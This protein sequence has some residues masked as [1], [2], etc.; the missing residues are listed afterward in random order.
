GQFGLPRITPRVL[1]DDRLVGLDDAGEVRVRG[2]GLRR[3]QVVEAQ[4]QRAARRHRYAVWPHGFAVGEVERDLDLRVAVAG[5]EHAGRLVAG[6]LPRAARAGGR[7][8]AFR[9]DPQALSDVFHDGSSLRS[10]AVALPPPQP[11][12][13]VAVQGQAM[14]ARVLALVPAVAQDVDHAF[15]RHVRQGNVDRLG[16][17]VGQG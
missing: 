8:V 9:D 13:A 14:G 5:I 6:Q 17:Q 3:V 15:D 2:H 16:R 4:V 7:D 1:H 11:A 10:T 12:V